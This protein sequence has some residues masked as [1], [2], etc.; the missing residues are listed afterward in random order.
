MK[1]RPAITAAGH[2]PDLCLALA[3]TVPPSASAARA[4]PAARRTRRLRGGRVRAPE[5]SR[6]PCPREPPARR[7]G[8]PQQGPRHRASYGPLWGCRACCRASRRWLVPATRP[9]G[10]PTSTSKV[11]ASRPP[12]SPPGWNAHP[13][14][15]PLSASMRARQ[16][17]FSLWGPRA[18]VLG[19]RDGRD[20]SGT[21]FNNAAAASRC[22][23]RPCTTGPS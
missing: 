11:R 14:P 6:R 8:E 19:R 18:P 21:T 17:A 4:G 3:L 20:R 7:Q 13:Q 15:L 2:N 1:P 22:A 9:T 12:S 16:F 5:E 23:A 10:R